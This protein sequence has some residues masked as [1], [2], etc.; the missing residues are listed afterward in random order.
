MVKCIY[1]RCSVGG[2]REP[3]CP[4]QCTNHSCLWCF[5]SGCFLSLL[6]KSWKSRMKRKRWTCAFWGTKAPGSGAVDF[7]STLQWL[8]YKDMIP[9][10]LPT[11]GHHQ[12][13]SM[14]PNT[15]AGHWSQVFVVLFP[16]DDPGASITVLPLLTSVTLNRSTVVH[17]PRRNY[18]FF[19]LHSVSCCCRM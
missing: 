9:Q 12:F 19:S 15:A 13:H 2:Q 16:L 1:H 18:L 3:S 6:F 7:M 11:Q 17:S 5:Q 14:G 8:K 10:Q 4:G